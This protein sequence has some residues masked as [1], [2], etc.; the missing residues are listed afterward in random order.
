M[1]LQNRRQSKGR[2]PL[3]KVGSLAS[4]I[5]ILLKTEGEKTIDALT[6][7]TGE[8]RQSVNGMLQR[9]KGEGLVFSQ[10]AQKGNRT[11]TTYRAVMEN[12]TG[13]GRDKVEFEVT[14]FVNECGE[15][16]VTAK[17]LNELATAREDNPKP[18][19]RARFYAAVPKPN[20]PARVRDIFHD[21]QPRSAS[22]NAQVLTID[23]NAVDITE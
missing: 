20:E 7:A 13:F 9:M 8:E 23:A 19:H 18:I 15:Y 22:K 11:I 3:L 1:A 12:E 21:D 4:R 16:S 10:P 14:F 2:N 6:R 5:F 17:V